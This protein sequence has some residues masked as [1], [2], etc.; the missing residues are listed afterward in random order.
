[1]NDSCIRSVIK[2]SEMHTRFGST[3][4]AEAFDI[5]PRSKICS[6]SQL[7]RS[8]IAKLTKSSYRKAE[9]EDLFT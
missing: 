5:L 4:S 1:L 8:I 3:T 2:G 9:R 7:Y 6:L